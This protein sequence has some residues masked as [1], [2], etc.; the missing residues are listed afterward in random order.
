MNNCHWATPIL[1]MVGKLAF[2]ALLFVVFFLQQEQLT[3]AAGG[4]SVRKDVI[5]DLLDKIA[6]LQVSPCGTEPEIHCLFL[7]IKETTPY[8]FP[9]T[10]YKQKGV[11]PSDIRLAFSGS[12]EDTIL[13]REFKI[14]DNNA[15]V[16]LWVSSLLLETVR[17][18]KTA[19]PSDKQ[20]LNALEAIST[21]HDKN[22][23]NTSRIVFWPQTYNESEGMW[24]CSPLNLNKVVNMGDDF[25]IFAANV[26]KDLDLK[27][28][29]DEILEFV[30]S[31]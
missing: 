29:S 4:D 8:V 18:D 10:F 26:L 14:F 5:N 28:Y 21:Y 17:F 9:I 16:T 2:A 1:M 24:T 11:Y 27:K 6:K 15:F 20:L 13:R 7:Q 23:L 25:L 31:M 30:D 22:F 3:C 19:R 12:P